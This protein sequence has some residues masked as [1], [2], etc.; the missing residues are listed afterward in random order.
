MS[1]DAV[2]AVALASSAAA[3]AGVDGADSVAAA[4]VPGPR[5]ADSEWRGH[6]DEP[7]GRLAEAGPDLMAYRLQLWPTLRCEYVSASARAIT[8]HSPQ[9]YYNRPQLFF[10]G[11]HPDDRPRVEQ[12]LAELDSGA[13]S[14]EV[15]W[16]RDTGTVGWG[17]MRLLPLLDGGGR[18][19]G[20]DGV[21]IDVTAR[22][23]AEVALCVSDD[24]FRRI[25]HDNPQPMW[26]VDA[27]SRRFLAVNSA[28][29]RLYG[30][31]AAEFA[32]L[33]IADLRVDPEPAVVADLARARAGVSQFG[34]RHRLRDGRVIDVEVTTQ[35]QEYEGRPAVLSLI[36]DVTSRL[37]VE[38]EMTRRSFHDSLTGLPNRELFLDR[39][40][41][42]LRR[43]ARRQDTAVAVLFI[44]VDRFKTVNDGLGHAVGDG[45]L[46]ALADRL[47]TVIRSD[48]TLARLGGDEFG[49]LVDGVASPEDARRSAQ[50][51]LDG[52]AEAIDVDEHSIALSLSVG[53]AVAKRRGSRAEEVV[54]DA[55]LAMYAAKSR[56]RGRL[57]PFVLSMRTVAEQGL[58]LDQDLRHAV[59]RQE[60]AL[61]FQPV[62]AVDSGA[63]IGC[64]ALVRWQHPTRGLLPPDV[65]I[66]MA[67]DTGLISEVDTWVI[68]EACAQ[69][70][71]WRSAGIVDL[72][73]AVN[74]SGIDIGCGRL[75]E[76]VQAALDDS[77]IPAHCLEIELTESVASIQSAVALK[78]LDCLRQRGVSVSI[79]DFG[80]GYSSLSKLATLS[81]DRL[82]VDRSF[83]A[84]IK[85]ADD[86]VPLVSAMIALAHELGL[87]VIAE[88]VET[89]VQLAFL[90][91]HGCELFQGYLASPPVSAGAF[92]DICRGAPRTRHPVT[93]PR[94]GAKR[95]GGVRRI[96]RIG[97]SKALPASSAP[98]QAVEQLSGKRPT[99]C[100]MRRRQVACRHTPTLS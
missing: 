19:I 35:G 18:L 42:A 9:E 88:G 77:G 75:V 56:G 79:D 15:R 91:R 45:M 12:A 30:Y 71:A 8:G 29:L 95:P 70:A 87:S 47:G 67:E 16:L 33:S 89:A 83:L 76:R 59:E 84:P 61:V 26:V 23:L 24:K 55:E 10:D 37:T 65:F 66:P 38:R 63:V 94:D 1:E 6:G 22:R 3:T 20:A 14:L 74:V 39:L 99:A 49:I 62:V 40:G 17:A 90:R 85:R 2:V 53:V 92:A 60:L 11:L 51:I 96:A 13:S 78:E 52:C 28:A 36:Q 25:F 21:V 5:H 43:R 72:F 73:V 98:D 86:K 7:F 58:S 4:D 32:S 54:R 100:S 57:E 68:R 31:T 48:D 27:E 81:I 41:H 34:A 69:M 80:T 93:A 97:S 82:K 64:E 50:R 46:R 44:D